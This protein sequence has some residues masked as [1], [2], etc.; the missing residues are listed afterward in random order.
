MNENDETA[1]TAGSWEHDPPAPPPFRPN[2]GSSSHLFRDF[3]GDYK[4]MDDRIVFS[5]TVETLLKHP[6]RITYEIITGRRGRTMR[7]LLPITILC[8]LLY[9]LIMG[10]FSG[11]PQTWVVPIKVAAGALL[12]A[13]ICLPS[14]YI[15]G[16]L[17]GNNQSFSQ[18]SGLL[19]QSIALTAI[20][21]TGFVPIAWIFSQSTHAVAFMGALHLGFWAT[22]TTFSLRLLT[23]AF[24]HL[25]QGSGVL[26]I[27]KLIFIVVTL[28]M[29]TMLRPLV[30]EF[31]GFRLGE[32]KFFA[33]HWAQTVDD[34][35]HAHHRT[36]R[37]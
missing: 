6:A 13:L 27:W 4:S 28:Q 12:S 14:L 31:D 11:G 17:S 3:A 22:A 16:C 7:I 21:L 33:A 18:V 34:N 37:P 26:R 1:P 19:L 32:K 24:S 15:F 8:M 2:A 25:N 36:L 23:T 29:C 9:G 35:K 20:L 30:G 5:K 10:S